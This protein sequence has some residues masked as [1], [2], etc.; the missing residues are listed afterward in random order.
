ML[1]QPP[2]YIVDNDGNRTA[3]ILSLPVYEELLAD[4]HDLAI[5]AERRA[6]STFSLEELRKKLG[7]LG[8]LQ[9]EI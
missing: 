9:S 3:V 2:Q 8:V 6:E 1:A 5:V 4:L 7:E